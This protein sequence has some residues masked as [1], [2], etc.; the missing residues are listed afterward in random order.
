MF[1]ARLGM[2]EGGGNGLWKTEEGR[3]AGR[4]LNVV[5][6]LPLVDGDEDGHS[7]GTEGAEGVF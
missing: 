2:L 4:L 1:R 6:C 7:G 3:E 5:P